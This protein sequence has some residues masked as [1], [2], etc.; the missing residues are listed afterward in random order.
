MK[1]MK[2]GKLLIFSAQL[3]G[4]IALMSQATHSPKFGRGFSPRVL[5]GEANSNNLAHSKGSLPKDSAKLNQSEVYDGTCGSTDT[6]DVSLQMNIRL[7]DLQ[8]AVSAGSS[9]LRKLRQEHSDKVNALQSVLEESRQIDVDSCRLQ[10]LI[11]VLQ[12]F[13]S[14][15]STVHKADCAQRFHIIRKVLSSISGWNGHVSAMLAFLEA[16]QHSILHQTKTPKLQNRRLSTPP[17]RH[18]SP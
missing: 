2:V 6:D 5:K 8:S 12:R 3:P 11:D 13:D 4:I 17:K 10:T 9:L 15:D 18:W 16:Q 14:L 1:K 7:M